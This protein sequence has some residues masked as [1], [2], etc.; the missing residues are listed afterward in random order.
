MNNDVLGDIDSAMGNMS[1]DEELFFQ[2]VFLAENIQPHLDGFTDEYIEQLLAYFAEQR[3]T[4]V[5]QARSILGNRSLPRRILDKI[6]PSSTD[7]HEVWI[8]RIDECVKQLEVE[9]AKRQGV[10]PDEDRR[11]GDVIKLIYD[12]RAAIKAELRAA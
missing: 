6:G 1:P 4:L 8:C 10:A 9:K 2:Y 11:V 3:K 12:R 5:G 7:L